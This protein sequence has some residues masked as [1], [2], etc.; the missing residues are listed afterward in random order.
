MSAPVEIK[1]ETAELLA[2][3]A[4]AR[5]LSVDDYLRTLLPP[6]NGE[7]VE[8]PLYESAT[9]EEWVDAFRKWAA[10]HP[11]QLVIADDSREGIYQERGE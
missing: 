6:T 8:R 3:Q 2:A 4:E 7:A 9:P 11:L 1:P 5:G 10:G